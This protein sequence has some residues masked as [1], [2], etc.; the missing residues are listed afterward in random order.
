MRI[1]PKGFLNLTDQTDSFEAHL[2]LPVGTQIVTRKAIKGADGKPIYPRGAVGAIVEVLPDEIHHY[3]IRFPTGG[4]WV[5]DRAEFAVRTHLRQT[6]VQRLQGY[7]DSVLY[8]HVIYRCI[9]GS[10]AYGLDDKDSDTDRR[11][12]YLSPAD[13]QW[14]LMGAPEQIERN[15]TQ[16]V[17]WELEKFLMLGVKANP[18]ILECLYTPLVESSKPLG[19]ELLAMRDI[20]LSRFIYHTYNGYVLSQFKKLEADLRIKGE[21]SW[22]HAMHLIRLLLSGITILREGFVPVRVDEYRDRLLAIKRAE[23]P[24]A[25][26]NAWRLSLHRE[27]DRAYAETKLPER[28]NY[29]RADQFLIRARRS[30]VK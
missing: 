6:V 13:L 1:S 5:M 29:E 20:F 3:R 2:I 28:P 26:V 19:E 21:P 11:G 4:E 22:K 12:T 27:F 15:E 23:T 17:Y 24:W 7:D 30:M 14:S 25:E 8:Q 10:R 16:E 18:N 9:V